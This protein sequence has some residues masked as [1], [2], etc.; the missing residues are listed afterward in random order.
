MLAKIYRPARS[1]MQSG[2]AKTRGWILEFAAEAAPAAEALMGWISSAD[3]R[4]QVRME[5][6]TE[7]EAIAFARAHAIPHEV[8]TPPETRRIVKAYADNFAFT[9]REPWSH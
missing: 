5:F 7:A 4:G 1:A 2:Q 9:R 8:V 3:T 6:D